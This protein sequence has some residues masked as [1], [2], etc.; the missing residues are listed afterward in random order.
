VRALPAIAFLAAA[1]ALPGQAF[2]QAYQCTVPGHIEVPRTPQ[3]DGPVRRAPVASYILAA[4]WSPEYC[5][6]N[7]KRSTL[8]CSGRNGSFG[9]VLHGLWPQAAYGAAPQW[10]PTRLRPS[11]RTIRRYLCMTPSPSLMARE[12]A[13]H[14]SCMARKPSTYFKVSEILWRSIEWPDADYLSRKED[15]TAGDLR[16]AFVIANPGWQASQVG[17]ETNSRGWL[18]GVRLCYNRRFRPQ[19][20]AKRDYGPADSAPLNIWRGL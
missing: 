15:L 18:R 6:F 8:Q 3:P 20:C 11:P 2:A 10:C 16:E 12:W 19:N 9:F 7:G 4:S 17:I 14:G 13:K 1:V 5:K